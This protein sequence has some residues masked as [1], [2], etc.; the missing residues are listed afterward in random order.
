[1]TGAEILT[2]WLLIVAVNSI[3]VMSP[4]PAFALTLRNAIAY[5]RRIALLSCLGLGVGLSVHVGM[6]LFG[7]ATILSQSVFLF[8]FIKYAG[9]A[10]LIY[11]GF[12]ALRAKKQ[13]QT[14]KTM[15]K[16]KTCISNIEGFKSGF[17]TNLLNPKIIVFFT[18]V[19]A[20]FISPE[21]PWYVLVLYGITSVMLE[22]IWFSI[23]SIILT[24]ARIKRRFMGVAH[25]IERACGG[26]LIAL[27]VKLALSKA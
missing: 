12:K 15:S 9:A 5:N 13:D 19:Y 23:V 6:V 16:A 25:W 10:Y 1:M 17:F 24:D 11:I 20:Q 14:N 21:A 18:A 22:I 3:A 2:S 4:G 27:G 8:N 26:L 7:F